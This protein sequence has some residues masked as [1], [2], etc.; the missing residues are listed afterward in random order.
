MT[1]DLCVKIDST[2]RGGRILIKGNNLQVHYLLCFSQGTDTLKNLYIV[3]TI[4][5]YGYERVKCNVFLSGRALLSC[6]YGMNKDFSCGCET[7][8]LQWEGCRSMAWRCESRQPLLA[9]CLWNKPARNE[10]EP[11]EMNSRNL[12]WVQRSSSLGWPVFQLLRHTEVEMQWFPSSCW[13][14]IKSK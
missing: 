11:P 3:S 12:S 7:K 1:L 4:K 14:G 8:R 10:R 9:A 6:L 5:D 2:A 13:G